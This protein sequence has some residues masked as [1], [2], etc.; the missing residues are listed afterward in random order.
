MDIRRDFFTERELK[1]L[2]AWFREEQYDPEE[3][4]PA[5][6][7][8][9]LDKEL[10][11]MEVD[12]KGIRKSTKDAFLVAQISALGGDGHDMIVSNALAEDRSKWYRMC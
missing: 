9:A 10:Q 7:R 4:D 11:E 5:Y 1:S 8:A 12:C 2:T 6:Y 3:Q